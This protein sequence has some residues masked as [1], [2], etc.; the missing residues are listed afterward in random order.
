MNIILAPGYVL[1]LY[2]AAEG[3]WLLAFIVAGSAFAL[4]VA[5]EN[6]GDRMARAAAV[7]A[8]RDRAEAVRPVADR[9]D[10]LAESLRELVRIADGLIEYVDDEDKIGFLPCCGALFYD[11]HEDDCVVKEARAALLD[12]DRNAE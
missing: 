10:R 6:I 4:A 5:L 7:K 9:A 1:F 12:H 3:K 11:P 2:L 8:E